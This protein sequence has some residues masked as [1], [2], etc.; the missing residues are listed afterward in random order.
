MDIIQQVVWQLRWASDRSLHIIGPNS[1]PKHHGTEKFSTNT[2][3][4][5]QPPKKNILP[6]PHASNQ[7]RSTPQE[8]FAY[9]ATQPF[10][11]KFWAAAGF[12]RSDRRP[13]EGATYRNERSPASASFQE[14]YA[15]HGGWRH[16]EF[17]NNTLATL[18]RPPRNITY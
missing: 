9:G 17:A 18:S 16:R 7:N 4:H 2:S 6:Y 14:H 3:M 11:P 10:C 8:A 12:W 5:Y 15:I 13:S 1:I